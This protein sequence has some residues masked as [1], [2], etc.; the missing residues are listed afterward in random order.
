MTS[1][2]CVEMVAIFLLLTTSWESHTGRDDMSLCQ[3][4]RHYQVRFLTFQ[5]LFFFLPRRFLAMPI[6][7][8][9]AMT[10]LCLRASPGAK[11]LASLQIPSGDTFPAEAVT[12]LLPCVRACVWYT[13]IHA[14]AAVIARRRR[15]DPCFATPP[16]QMCR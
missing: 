15:K 16:V 3:R 5:N 6:W 8:I 11:I 2:R 10:H 12:L 13:S 4:T 9:A 14:S 1:V 7:V